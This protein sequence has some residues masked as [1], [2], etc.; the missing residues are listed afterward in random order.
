MNQRQSAEE[1]DLVII[2]ILIKQG[3]STC[4]EAVV[5]D[6]VV[7]VKVCRRSQLCIK[8]TQ[9]GMH[10][11]TRIC[12]LE[13]SVQRCPHQV[14]CSQDYA[15]DVTHDGG[16]LRHMQNFVEFAINIRHLIGRNNVCC[17]RRS[18]VAGFVED[19]RSGV[20]DLGGDAI[21][22]R[23]VIPHRLLPGAWC[24]HA[25]R[26]R[27]RQSQ[28]ERG[29]A[30]DVFLVYVFGCNGSKVFCRQSVT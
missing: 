2:Q 5:V 18:G 25:A 20:V 13:L 17:D 14:R 7:A 12:F 27:D 3:R 1:F 16:M 6:P 10:P 28:S 30:L 21:N 11:E 23:R 24:G 15:A 4:K 26:R 9:R 29:H 8:G 19:R 22:V